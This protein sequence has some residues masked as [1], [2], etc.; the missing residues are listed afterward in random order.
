M[1]GFRIFYK[2]EGGTQQQIDVGNVNMTTLTN[3]KK[4]TSYNISVAVRNTMYVGPACS[5]T[6]IRTLEDAPDIG[7][8]YTTATKINDT[9]FLVT[10]QPLTTAQSNGVVTK[11]QLDTEPGRPTDVQAESQTKTS[12][13]VRW[14]KPLPLSLVVYEYTIEVKGSKPYWSNYSFSSTHKQNGTRTNM[15]IDSLVPGT[16]YEFWVTASTACGKSEK[17]VSSKKDTNIDNPVKPTGNSI[18]LKNKFDVPLWSVDPVNGPVSSYQVIVIKGNKNVSDLPTNISDYKDAQELYVTAELKPNEIKSPFP[19]GDNKIYGQYKN[20][21]L[22]KGKTYTIAERA[23]T[24]ENQGKIYA[25]QAVVVAT[26]KVTQEQKG[27]ISPVGPAVG[28][29]V[30]VLLI[31][32]MVVLILLIKRRRQKRYSKKD[33]TVPLDDIEDQESGNVNEGQENELVQKDMAIPPT[34]GASVY[35]QDD[36]Y[37]EVI[38][39]AKPIPIRQFSE[40]VKST[41]ATEYARLKEEYKNLPNTHSFP[42]TVAK[43]P[44]NKKKNRY[45]NAIPFDHSRVIIEQTDGDEDSDYINASYVTVSFSYDPALCQP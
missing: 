7:P 19:V 45:G 2:P 21:P 22:D 42:K 15:V 28:A 41:K 8:Q 16:S 44:V 43:K 39:I 4:Y 26:I 31:L 29:V 1:T 32:V 3:L 14:E 23:I 24:T 34:A 9:T 33:S 36:V 37:D 5:V 17:S 38:D 12:I 30:I 13:R 27:G 35:S 10:W 40:Y 11:T 20:V 6:I 18:T 25:G